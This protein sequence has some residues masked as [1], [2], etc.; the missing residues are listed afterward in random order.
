MLLSSRSW[1]PQ[2]ANFIFMV[3][4]FHSKCFGA[5]EIFFAVS[6][7]QKIEKNYCN[8]DIGIH[9]ISFG[10]F[11]RKQAGESLIHLIHFYLTLTSNPARRRAPW[12]HSEN[13][14]LKFNHFNSNFIFSFCP[15]VC[16]HCRG[17]FFIFI[18]ANISRLNGILIYDLFWVR[19]KMFTEFCFCSRKNS[20]HK[21]GVSAFSAFYRRSLI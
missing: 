10:I 13:W 2:P 9:R 21:F 5:P 15:S 3:P 16:L 6:V 20:Q 11:P 17:D 18:C 12:I 14:K 8:F 1:P 19:A 4:S 7:A